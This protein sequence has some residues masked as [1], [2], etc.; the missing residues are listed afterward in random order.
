ML[1]RSDFL[2]RSDVA[3]LNHGS[4]GACPRI[5]LEE[6][7]RWVERMEQQPVL[8]FREADELMQSARAALASYLG[9]RARDLIYVTNSTYGVNV[10]AHAFGDVLAP[11]DE[12]LTTD[13]EYGACDRAWSQY[14]VS[15][16]IRY[17]RAEIPIPVPSAEEIVEII[18]SKVTPRTKVLFLSHITSPTAVRFP[19]EEL[20]ARAKEV[21]IR[22]VID[23]SHAPGHIPLDLS[24]LQADVYTAN[25]HKWMCTPKGSA[26]LWVTEELQ[27]MMSPL[28]VSWGRES[29][30]QQGGTFIA[31]QEY[32]GTRDISPFL[33]VPFVLQLMQEQPWSAVQSKARLLAQTAMEL[34]TRISG[35]S[36]MCASG[37]DSLLQM[38]AVTLPDATDV[39]HMKEWLYTERAVEVVVHRWLGYPILRSSAHIHTSQTDVGMLGE[40]VSDY[41]IK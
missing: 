32:L 14:C 31:E 36:S 21:G 23:G 12:I 26:F 17:V 5:V 30:W 28:A 10:A 22:S 15:K 4:F 7:R 18:W 6:Q 40:A 19:V 2:L 11:G 38:T 37:Q 16:G 20:C 13:H 39:D 25:C 34:L 41:L 29:S 33:T 27:Y 24:T 1:S 8:F 3:F 35:V 9:A